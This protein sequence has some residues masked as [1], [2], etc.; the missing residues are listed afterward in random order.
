MSWYPESKQRAWWGVVA[1]GGAWW[2]VVGHGGAWWGVVL[3]ERAY[4]GD[5]ENNKEGGRGRSCCLGR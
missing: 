1:C 2:G 5:L 4:C 3:N